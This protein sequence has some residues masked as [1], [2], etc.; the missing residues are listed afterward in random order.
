MTAN[1]GSLLDLMDAIPDEAAAVAHFRAIRWPGRAFCPYC[2]GRRVCDFSDKR[3]HK[4]MDCRQKLSIKVRTVSENSKVPFRKWLM[5]I[6]LIT[7]FKEGI[8]STQIAKDIKV[9]QKTA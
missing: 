2:G 6:W 8:A 4:C 7:F 1:F 5:A 9:T 3:T